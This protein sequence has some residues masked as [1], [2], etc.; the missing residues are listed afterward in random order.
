MSKITIFQLP[1]KTVSEANNTEHWTKKAKRHRIQKWLVKKVFLDNKFKFKLPIEITFIRIATRELDKEDNLP[2]SI[3]YI[4]DAIAD[5]IIPGLAP[6]RADDS[7][8]I[9]WKYDQR[10][11]KVRENYIEVIVKEL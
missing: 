3:K 1:I 5:L 6:G 2:M 11:G 8:E 4:K 7:K 9:T 10:K